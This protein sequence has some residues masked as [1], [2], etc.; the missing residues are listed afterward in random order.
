MCVYRA[1]GLHSYTS[2]ASILCYGHSGS[3]VDVSRHCTLSALE[4]RSCAVIAV[5]ASR[6]GLSQRC[7]YFQQY[8]QQL[9]IIVTTVL[10]AMV[11]TVWLL[12][13]IHSPQRNA[14]TRLR[15]HILFIYLFI[16]HICKHANSCPATGIELLLAVFDTHDTGNPSVLKNKR[17]TMEIYI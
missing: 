16:R 3:V 9:I 13:D 2:S 14:E 8:I 7:H 5:P 6:A 1:W 10:G 12:G 4:S 17:N 11:I 15:T